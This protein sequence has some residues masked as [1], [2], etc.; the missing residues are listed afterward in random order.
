MRVVAVLFVLESLSAGIVA[1][2]ASQDHHA[3]MDKRGAMVMGFDQERTVHHF[4]LLADGGAIDVGV[5][6]L[7][8]TTNRDAIR[9]HLP[10]IAAMFG[11]G[12]FEAPMLVHDSRSVP[13]TT[14]MAARKQAI[15]Y[16][17]VETAA[18]GRVDIFTTDPEALSAIHAF[19]RFQIA[20]H[21]T[22]DPTTV[23]K[24]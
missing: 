8:D 9:S 10:H 24:R 11:D 5:R 7:S 3:A 19:L 22:G 12:N 20:D 21:K 13:G 17:Y 4:L 14:V 15:R 16:Q 18:G 6:N 23:R 2:A 1:L